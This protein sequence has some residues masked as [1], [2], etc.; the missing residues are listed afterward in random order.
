[1]CNCALC[2]IGTT[3]LWLYNR[4]FVYY[5]LVSSTL[6]LFTN[7]AVTFNDK[8]D[9]VKLHRATLC[10]QP[11]RLSVNLLTSWNTNIDEAT[12]I[13]WYWLI[14]ST[15]TGY[16]SKIETGLLDVVVNMNWITSL[17]L[18]IFSIQAL[19]HGKILCWVQ[20]L[21]I[22][23]CKSVPAF[24]QQ[25]FEQLGDNFRT[26]LLFYRIPWWHTM[27]W[28]TQYLWYIVKLWLKFGYA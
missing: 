9:F 4:L 17:G 27:F 26:T 2:I 14:K 5:F 23:E 15:F 20:L 21:F 13:E 18:S 6:L 3:V 22:V 25:T 11:H 12:L 8:F 1:M 7:E 24:F 16:L 19:K 28:I 10:V